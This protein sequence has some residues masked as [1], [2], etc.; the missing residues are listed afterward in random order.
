MKIAVLGTGMGRERHRGELAELGHDVPMGTRDSLAEQIQRA[1]PETKVVKSL[2]TVLADLMVAPVRLAGTPQRR[3]RRRRREG[4]G[5]EP[6]GGLRPA[7]GGD[8][9]PR[10]HPVR[11]RAERY[12]GLSFALLGTLG[13]FEFNIAV[14]R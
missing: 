4:H 12:A 1:F 5:A 11:T 13:T 3:G 10:R 6:A 7:R 14:A 8:R 9:R 2:N